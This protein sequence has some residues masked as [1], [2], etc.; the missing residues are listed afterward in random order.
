MNPKQHGFHPD[1]SCL[2]QI[3]E[4][5]NKILEEVEKSNNVDVIYLAFAKAFSKVDHGRLLNKFKKSE[6]IVERIHNFQSNRQ[7]NNIK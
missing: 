2:S 7:W 6:L 3:L 5:H 1:I 4:H